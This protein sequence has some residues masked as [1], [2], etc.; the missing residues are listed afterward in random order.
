V[1]EAWL[2]VIVVGASTMAM[3]AAGPVVVGG[4]AFPPRLTRL[5]AALA[6]ALLGALIAT[7]LLDGGR[8]IV[9]D[10]RVAGLA[11]AAACLALRTPLLV[12][13]IAA[14]ATTAVLRAL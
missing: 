8:S 12:A 4:R 2:V 1:G 11:S 5:L 13:I 3:K 6:P 14:A 10:E 7:Q 9:I